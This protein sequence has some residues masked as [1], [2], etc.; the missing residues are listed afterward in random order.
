LKEVLPNSQHSYEYQ[1]DPSTQLHGFF[2][3]LAKAS[4]GS[5]NRSQIPGWSFFLGLHYVWLSVIMVNA[6]HLC[7]SFR[8]E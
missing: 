3:C 4:L 2:M 6:K 5:K 1:L 7:N 8:I